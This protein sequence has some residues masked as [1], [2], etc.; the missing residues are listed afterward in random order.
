MVQAM[1]QRG[2]EL[3]L[4]MGY[5]LEGSNEACLAAV[6]KYPGRFA[7]G[8]FVDPREGQAAIETVRCYHGEGFRIVKLFPNYGYY[9]DDEALLP[10]FEQVAGMGMAILSHCGWLAAGNKPVATYFATP[11]RFEKPIRVFPQMTFIMAHMGGIPGFLETVMLTTRTPNTYADCSPGQGTW[12]LENAGPMAATIPPE[13]LLWGADNKDPG[14]TMDRH[15]AAMEKIGL[16]PHFEK[17]F[18]ANARGILEKIG[19]IRNN[20]V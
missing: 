16:G 20:V 6:K 5:S 2:I 15:A 19:A 18:H 7:G 4:V 13:K 3:T 14:G 11:G 12:V 1:D 17:I 8:V 10:F 9:P